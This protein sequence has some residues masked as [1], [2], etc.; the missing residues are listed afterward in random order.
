M[1]IGVVTVSILGWATDGL[2]SALEAAFW[3]CLIVL[4]VRAMVV[5]LIDCIPVL[6][7]Q[8]AGMPAQAN[9]LPRI[10]VGAVASATIGP[11]DYFINVAG[12]NASEGPYSVEETRRMLASGGISASDYV[13]KE[14]W[15]G[16]RRIDDLDEFQNLTQQPT[17]SPSDPTL[18]AAASSPLPPSVINAARPKV[19]AGPP[20]ELRDCCGECLSPIRFPKSLAGTQAACSACGAGILLLIPWGVGRLLA[21]G[22]FAIGI[23]A[24]YPRTCLVAGI[25]L[26]GIMV[27]LVVLNPQIKLEFL[28]LNRANLLDRLPLL[29]KLLFIAIRSLFKPFGSASGFGQGSR[30]ALLGSHGNTGRIQARTLLTGC[31][32]I[33]L[34]VTLYFTVPMMISNWRYS[35]EAND[36][37][38]AERTADV[39]RQIQAIEVRV[40]NEADPQARLLLFTQLDLHRVDPLLVAHVSRAAELSKGLSILLAS[41]QSDVQ[42]KQDFEAKAGEAF[43]AF[44]AILGMLGSKNARNLDEFGR[45]MSVG[46]QVGEL[47]GQIGNAIDGLEADKQLAAKYQAPLQSYQ[48]EFSQ[49]TEERNALGSILSKKYHR[50]FLSFQ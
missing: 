2:R 8:S 47:A 5:L 46:R 23:L 1:L 22:M 38:M 43:A 49:L 28:N 4:A 6:R 26:A 36:P 45:N 34:A 32:L 30:N 17:P 3:F 44:G 37:I 25:C 31:V 33:V 39:W 19:V 29:G 24:I 20:E 35:S 13:W 48:S 41:L 14:G 40:R 27:S 18:P 42:A 11:Q 9:D 12:A 15:M 10:Q 21:A 7:R 50:P 16:W